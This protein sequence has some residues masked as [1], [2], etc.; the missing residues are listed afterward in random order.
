ML[1]LPDWWPGQR[2][3]RHPHDRSDP[4]EA[5]GRENATG[6]APHPKSKSWWGT[7]PR[8]H[9][10]ALAVAIVVAIIAV[11]GYSIR[12]WRLF[13]VEAASASLTIESDP[14]G[15]EVFA[16]GVRQGATPLS[17][18]LVP[19]EHTFELVSGT[20]RKAFRATAREGTSVVHHVQFDVQHA[21][22]TKAWLSV[23]TD[24]PQQRVLLDGKSLGVSPLLAS[25]LEPGSHK[26]QV[27]S[28]TGTLERRVDLYAG[29]TASVIITAPVGAAPAGPAAGW[30]SVT[31]PVALQIV[32]AG[33]VIGSTSAKLLLPVGRHELQMTNE[34]L[35]IV[36]RRTV[37]ISAGG[38]TSLTVGVPKARLSINALPWAEAWLDG[39]RLGE[40]PIGN[41]EVTVGTHEV[42]VRHPEFGE[43]RQT[44][45]VSLKSPARVSIDMRK[46]Q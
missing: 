46:P 32:E 21:A 7:R 42:M 40:T 24:P 27:V 26:V 10:T 3:S 9:R 31:S 36:E 28:T 33:N 23:V 34:S 30:L 1:K 29:E 2:T 38:T 17:V 19:G 43:R 14:S 4:L 15:A 25:D 6:G 44:V 8:D 45:T 12:K 16:D 37:Q 20:R 5:F 35:G 39:A 41:Y 18:S 22:P 11:S 13:N